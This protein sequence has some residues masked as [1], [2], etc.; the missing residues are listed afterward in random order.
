MVRIGHLEARE[1]S[2]EFDLQVSNLVCSLLVYF[3]YGHL[4]AILSYLMTSSVSK[5]VYHPLLG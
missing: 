2:F 3:D 1:I 5:E 4:K